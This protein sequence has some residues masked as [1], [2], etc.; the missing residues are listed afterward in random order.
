M[1]N[2]HEHQHCECDHCLHYCKVCMLVYCC[3]CK[4]NWYK[5]YYVYPYSFTYTVG[6]SVSLG[7]STV[8]NCS[9]IH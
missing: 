2:Q 8:N 1:C 7:N 5:Y 4:V 9:H 6:S 3:R